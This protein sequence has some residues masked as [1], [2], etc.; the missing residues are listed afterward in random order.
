MYSRSNRY[1]SRWWKF[2]GW[3]A[4]CT[5]AAAFAQQPLSIE[6]AV[7]HALKHNAGMEQVRAS[8]SGK[9]GDLLA[10]QRLNRPKLT[11]EFSVLRG[12]GEPTSFSAVNGQN[13]PNTPT[14]NK[15]TG[16]YGIGTFIFSAPIYQNGAFFF[17]ASPAEG[18]AGGSL[19]KAQSESDTQAVE[20]A[21][22]V[23]KAYLSALSASEQ[24]ALHE[25]ALAKLQSHVEVV[26]KRKLSGF[27]THEDELSA[28]AALAESKSNL[29]AARRLGAM[30]RTQ[31]SLALGQGPVAQIAIAPVD[32]EF[33]HAPEIEEVIKATIDAQPAL[34][35]QVAQTQVAAS[36][37][38]LQRA[39]YQPKLTFDVSRTEAGNFHFKGTNRFYSAGVKLTMPL[40]DFG[41]SSAKVNASSFLIQE[42][43]Q[44]AEQ[45]RITLIQAAYQAYYA[46]QD[47]L[48][49]TE[50]GKAAVAKVAFQ[51]RQSAAKQERKLVSLDTVLQDEAAVL[52]KR[53]DQV[54][55]HYEAWAAWADFVKAVG[56]PFTRRLD[57]TAP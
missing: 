27:A 37:L 8:V 46:Y 23:A 9:E 51:A 14:I 20:L 4:G 39:E 38:D 5:A 54:K 44:K 48:D 50:A 12:T 31:L 41:Q 7:D 45:T 28:E 47:A 1:W 2:A 25:L 52:A 57:I 53:V 33:P 13:D 17:G 3:C 43:Q 42:S 32:E 35:T 56:R 34:R 49:K 36:N 21:N 29:N 30:Q 19:K 55:L 22:Q 10:A 40:L 16:N 6:D 11:A 26:R 15:L 18:M 24:V